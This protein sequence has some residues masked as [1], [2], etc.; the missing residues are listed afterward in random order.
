MRILILMATRTYRAEAFLSAAARLN[1]DV[2]VGTDTEHLLAGL[3]P[4]ALVSLDLR[5]PKRAV[6]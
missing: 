5:R 4:D 1:V 2:T 6:A 3:T